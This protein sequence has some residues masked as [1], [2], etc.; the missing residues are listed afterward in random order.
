MQA[1]HQSVNRL[2]IV[3]S[4]IQELITILAETPVDS[5]IQSVVEKILEKAKKLSTFTVTDP[6]DTKKAV[7]SIEKKFKQFLANRKKLKNSRIM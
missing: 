2:A 6:K 3:R 5:Q 7:E 4:D 1:I